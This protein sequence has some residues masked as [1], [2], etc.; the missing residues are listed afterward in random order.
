MWKNEAHFRT[1]VLKWAKTI[2]IEPKQIQMRPMT[3]KWASCSGK[4]YLTFSKLLLNEKREFGEYVIVHELLHLKIPNHSKL[5]K[6]FMITYMPDWK[7]RAKLES[8]N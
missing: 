4:G 3:R 6:S 7:D 1:S 2:K 8:G 5:F